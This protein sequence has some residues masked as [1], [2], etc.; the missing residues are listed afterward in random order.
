MSEARAIVS[1]T[2]L[3][4][5]TLAFV[6]GAAAALVLALFISR[7]AIR[8]PATAAPL[9][10]AVVVAPNGERTAEAWI[11][12]LTAAEL[13]A[14]LVEPQNYVG[15]DHLLILGSLDGN[16]AAITSEVKRRIASGGGIVV[17]GQIPSAVAD[18]LG[19]RARDESV[20]QPQLQIGE[21]STPL[22]ARVG[23]GLQL[24]ADAAA[25]PILEESPEITVDARWAGPPSAAIA[26]WMRGAARVAWFGIAVDASSLER[27]PPIA[28]IVRAATRWAAGQPISDGA[29]RS[30]SEV[31]SFDAASRQEAQT[32]GLGYSADQIDTDELDV[33]VVNR[34]AEA[35]RNAQVR[36]WLPAGA[37]SAAIDPPLFFGSD[38]TL[39]DAG[40]GAYDLMVPSIRPGERLRYEIELI[41]P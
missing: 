6:V 5:G 13:D 28:V 4:Y 24:P 37:R 19:V 21:R 34:G 11:T 33:L 7:G 27:T 9:P 35:I 40:E 23:P 26:H 18:L 17:I 3:I 12:A 10:K 41:G 38:A 29:I 20:T 15:G 30:R 39:Q 2:V 22:L 1:R 31:S 14:T 32:R 8:K 16:H 25:H 36:I